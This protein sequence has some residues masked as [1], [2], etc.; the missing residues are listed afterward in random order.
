MTAVLGKLFFCSEGGKMLM[1]FQMCQA[2]Q[3]KIFTEESKMC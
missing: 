2:G 3:R 1:I